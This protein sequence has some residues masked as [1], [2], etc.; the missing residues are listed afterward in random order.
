MRWLGDWAGWSVGGRCMEVSA[1]GTSYMCR[2]CVGALFIPWGGRCTGVSTCGTSHM[3][4]MRIGA[5][6]VLWGWSDSHCWAAQA[7]TKVSTRECER[8]V[9]WE[10]SGGVNALARSRPW[11][12]VVRWSLWSVRWWDSPHDHTIIS[13]VGRGVPRDSPHKVHIIISAVGPFALR[14]NC[15]RKL[16]R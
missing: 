6:F 10:H 12:V 13:Y 9:V 1:C 3:C 11:G 5:L 4:R 15:G 16:A 8:A 2:M 7:G 14:E